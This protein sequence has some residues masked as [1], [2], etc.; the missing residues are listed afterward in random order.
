MLEA[1]GFLRFAIRPW[2]F[3][4]SCLE[5]PQNSHENFQ[6]QMPLGIFLIYHGISYATQKDHGY[7]RCH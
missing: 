7:F 2:K 5:G 6:R 1:L 3:P 4:A